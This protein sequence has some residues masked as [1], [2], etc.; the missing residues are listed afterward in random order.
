MSFRSCISIITLSFNCLGTEV[1]LKM[2]FVGGGRSL[3]FMKVENHWPTKKGR[4]FGSN[5][6]IWSLS[7]F[8]RLLTLS[9]S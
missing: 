7:H 4:G 5:M 6:F 3:L 9:E 1:L 8:D 2:T